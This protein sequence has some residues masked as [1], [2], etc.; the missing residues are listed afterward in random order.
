LVTLASGDMR[1]ALN[2]LQVIYYLPKSAHAAHEFITEETIYM[3]TGS[4]LPA[5]IDLIVD[6]LFNSDFSDAY[7]STF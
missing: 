6:W 2:I 4:P 5:D 1:K 7:N 3:T